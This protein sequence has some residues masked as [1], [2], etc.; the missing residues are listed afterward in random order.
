MQPGRVGR[1]EILAAIGKGGMGEVWKA[2]DTRLGREVAIKTLPD[3]FAK[4]ADR[5][6][7]FEREA[8]LLA[9]LNHP[10]IAALYGLDEVDGAQLLILELVEGETL[11]DRLSAGAIPLD[12]ALDIARQI[13]DAVEAAH[14]AGV[15]H[16][17]L[18]PAN[19]QVTPDGKVK[20]LDFGLAKAFVDGRSEL[21]LSHSP[22]LS[23]TATAHG[24][25]LGTAAYMSPEQARGVAVDKR[26]DIWAIGCI[27]YEMLA[28]RRTFGGELASDVMA[29][30]LKSEPDYTA[31][32]PAIPARLR[33]LI[34]RCLQKDPKKRWRDA[35]DVRVELELV[36]TAPAE[37]DREAHPAPSRTRERLLWS[38]AV[39]LAALAT[40]SAVA[41]FDAAGSR[42]PA[43]PE[44]DL[45][46]FTVSPPNGTSL[47]TGGWNV[48]F[49]V[50]PNGRWLAFTATS[51]DGRSRLWVRPMGS[52]VAQVVPGTEGATS[53]FWSPTSEWLGFSVR[54]VLHR[55]RI[56]G[57]SPEMIGATRYYTGSAPNAAW[58]DDVILYVAANGALFKV[59]VQG[60]QPAQV[61]TLDSSAKERSHAWPQFLEDG[62]HFLYLAGGGAL[63]RIYVGSLDDGQRTLVTELPVSNSTIRYSAG[64]LFY[65]EN[66][67]LWAQSFDK[68]SRRLVGSRHRVVSGIPAAGPAPFSV[69]ETGV[70]AYWTLPLIQQAAQLQWIDRKGSRLGRVGS[71]AVYDGFDLSR[72]DSRLL[73]AQAGKDGIELWVMDLAAGGESSFPLPYGRGST[74]PVWKPDA[75]EFVFMNGGALHLGRADGTSKDPIRL[76][77]PTR[78]QLAQDW[79]ASGDDLLYE[80]WSQENGIDLVVWQSKTK[81]IQRLGWNTTSNEF[82]GRLS[83]DNRWMAYV[84]DQ[85]GRNEVWVAAYPS[86]QP[87]RQISAGSHVTWRDDGAELYYISSEG[88]LV[89]VPI[90]TQ[91]SSIEVKPGTN[92]FRIPGTID[93]VAG[94]RNIYQPGRGG[95]RF[96]VAV[97]SEAVI[98]PINVVLNWP[99]LLKEQSQ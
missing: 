21:N 80:D 97:R 49:A 48:P 46:R 89:A 90:S 52:D 14:E 2:R 91:G 22:T 38:S 9:S 81:R 33:A 83:P 4:D 96:L 17:D 62:R 45:V 61:T 41:L 25:I 82:G 24:V 39:V 11:A 66:N 78:N 79:T 32:P 28:G 16:R 60:G 86:G 3:A 85:T 34:Q 65:V 6:A 74:V 69:S 76:T 5:L 68:S 88:Q 26:A 55:V 53:P 56:P 98:P 63:V 27:L 8:K 29:S 23:L 94:S 71:P 42:E 43:A 73:S 1:Y 77:D 50:S 72:N 99:R 75:A 36:S 92:L 15:L 10:N 70:L 57:G 84:T 12:Q 19:V 7:R 51:E 59:P 20:V 54:N 37:L 31:L 87:R 67:V 93:I 35:G 47:Y 58:G 18:K 64:H 95:Q 30:V 44:G 40:W 13:V